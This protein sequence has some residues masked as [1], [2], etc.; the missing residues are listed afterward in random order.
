[1]KAGYLQPQTF[2]KNTLVLFLFITAFLV[3]YLSSQKETTCLP[4]LAGKSPDSTV[5][6][7]Q[8]NNRYGSQHSQKTPWPIF[9]W[10]GSVSYMCLYIA[11]RLKGN[12][13]LW[14]WELGPD[15]KNRIFPLWKPKSCHLKP[16]R[17]EHWFIFLRFQQQLWSSIWVFWKKEAACH[18]LLGSH[19]ILQ[20]Y[21]IR[22]T[23]GMVDN[24]H[25]TY[26]WHLFTCNGPVCPRSVLR[27]SET[28]GEY[29]FLEPVNWGLMEKLV[30]SPVKPGYL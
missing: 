4:L 9:S 7:N 11:V 10:N 28:A 20:F 8:R 13:V 21:L 19:L 17:K 24:N 16:A 29:F 3:K 14:T 12:M 5:S 23:T 1:M 6:P 2:Q 25:K 26:S 30:Y 27:S 18:S 22:V 15:G